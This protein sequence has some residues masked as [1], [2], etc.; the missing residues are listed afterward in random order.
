[1][2]RA[3]LS[4]VLA[5]GG[6]LAS[7]SWGTFTVPILMTGNKKEAEKQTT[8]GFNPNYSDNENSFFHFFFFYGSLP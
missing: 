6:K 8:E 4:L 2:E 5:T 1:M 7:S 3:G